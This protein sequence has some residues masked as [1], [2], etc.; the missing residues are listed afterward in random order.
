MV[1]L[2]KLLLGVNMKY[3]SMIFLIIIF[4]GFAFMLCQT[5]S[6]RNDLLAD[7]DQELYLANKKMADFKLE[8]NNLKLDRDNLDILYQDEI[9]NKK[10][11][12]MRNF[13]DLSELESFLAADKTNE[14]NFVDETYDCDNFAMDLSE[15]AAKIGYKIYLQTNVS[16]QEVHMMNSTIIEIPRQRVIFIE[17]QSDKTFLGPYLDDEK[18]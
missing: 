1:P 11:V 3:F 18:K 9:R 12:N 6:G 15:N 10:W 7:R 14:T 17:P 8:Y 2:I 5:I 13:R 16:N 4:A